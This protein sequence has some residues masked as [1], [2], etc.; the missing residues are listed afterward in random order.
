[1]V[2]RWFTADSRLSPFRFRWGMRKGRGHSKPLCKPDYTTFRWTRL[3]L[4]WMA[5]GN[6]LRRNFAWRRLSAPGG[7]DQ[8]HKGSMDSKVS[9][10]FW[11]K[12]GCHRIPLSNEAGQ[13]VTP[14]EDL[15]P[16]SRL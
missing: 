16:G 10:Q 8:I 12:R 13:T 6:E 9:G 1:M 14:G 3:L 7:R 4:K 15:N 5:F 2:Y 11:M